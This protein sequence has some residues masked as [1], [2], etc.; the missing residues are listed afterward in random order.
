VKKPIAII[1]VALFVDIAPATAKDPNQETLGDSAS[2]PES[3]RFAY[4]QMITRVLRENHPTLAEESMYGCLEG[5][6]SYPQNS[7]MRLKSAVVVCAN[8]RP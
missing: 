8:M 5:A 2:R 1:A 4:A 3:S 6:A 7:Q